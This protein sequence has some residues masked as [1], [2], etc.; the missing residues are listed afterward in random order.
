MRDEMEDL[1]ELPEEVDFTNG[2]RGRFSGRLGRDIVTVTLDA[3]VAEAFPNARDVNAAL[4]MLMK[5]AIASHRLM[6]RKA[7]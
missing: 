1:D 2:V 3:D 4:R 5:T 6:D 7:S